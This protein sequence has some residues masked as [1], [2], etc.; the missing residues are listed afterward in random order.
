MIKVLW[1]TNTPSLAENY[2]SNDSMNGGF[3]KSLENIMQ[4]KVDLSLAF[5][6][7]EQ[8]SPFKFGETSY[9][10]INQHSRGLYY[11][12]KTRVFNKLEPTDDV[13]VYLDI[14]NKVNPDIIHIHGTEGPFGL[15]LAHLVIP[16]VVS[17]QGN[18][19]VLEL[20]FFSGIS[21]INIAKNS[22]LK[23]WLT[24]E[25]NLNYFKRFK[26]QSIREK[27]IFKLSKNI[28]GRTYWDRRIT[29]ILSPHSTYFHNDEIL[30]DIFYGNVWNSKLSDTLHLY[31]T[32]GS[33]IYKGVETL[34]YCAH[35]LDLN[36]V[37]FSWK[38]AGIKADDNIIK[39]A[40]KSIKK[41]LSKNIKFLGI[42]SD[43]IIKAS[44]LDCNIYIAISHIEN[45]PN[46]LCEALI[47]GTPCIATNAGGTSKFIEDGKD[48][49]LIQDGD[50]F[51]MA[52]AILELRENY[53]TAITCGSTAREKALRRHD[54]ITIANDLLN[55]YKAI[56]KSD[57]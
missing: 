6:H 25:T 11:K 10:P 5:Y 30:K 13:K 46:S 21:R 24:F 43:Q 23:K 3:L 48:G 8:L 26:K 44:I 39:I 12:I 33:N 19:S 40:S 35:L 4:K 37:K 28:I 53:D 18:I 36:N 42:A 54:K 16:T 41:P 38:V 55:I 29:R 14:V 34:L 9:F 57:R 20:K 2:F 47:L 27:K 22:S 17:I 56:L 50:P 51:A 49:I 1:F 15:V 52:G 31:T 32:T 45:S 7:P